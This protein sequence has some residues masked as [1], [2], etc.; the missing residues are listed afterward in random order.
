MPGEN[1]FYTHVTAVV[2]AFLNWLCSSITL[3]QMTLF[4]QRSPH[5]QS[6]N[7]GLGTNLDTNWVLD[8]N[9][10]SFFKFKILSVTPTW[11]P[12]KGVLPLDH[13]SRYAYL[14]QQ[15]YTCTLCVPFSKVYITYISELAV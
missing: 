2:D 12:R 10:I 4:R 1:A 9:I 13:I 14:L 5:Y 11:N 7:Q 8:Q 15:G 6:D 3:N